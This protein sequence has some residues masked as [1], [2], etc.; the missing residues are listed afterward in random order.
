MAPEFIA[1]DVRDHVATV[2]LNRPPVNAMNQQAYRE[3]T[4]VFG[5]FERDRD[6]RVALLC[7]ASERAFCA[8]ADLNERFVN[9]TRAVMLDAGRVA[10]EAFW[11]IADCAV[12]VVGAINGPAL[13]AGL[14]IAA[15]CDLLVASE[16]AV[17]GLPEINVGLLG[18]GSHLLRMVGPYRMR[19][20]YYTGE[21]MPAQE[22]YR[23]GAVARVTEPEDLME[24]ARAIAAE[25]ARKS[26]IATRLAKESLNRTESLPIKDAYRTEQDYTARLRTFEDSKE[27]AVAFMERREPRFQWR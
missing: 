22:L 17:F 3:M 4:E 26:P 16:R 23:L 15:S 19:L 18:G 8:G 5:S 20:A 21:R 10:R 1:V 25:I 7:S 9:P 13:G 6:V 2:T 12:P 27:A 11:S 14:A 24:E